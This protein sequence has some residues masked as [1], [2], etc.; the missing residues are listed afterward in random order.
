MAQKSLKI[1]GH[2]NIESFNFF[3]QQEQYNIFRTSEDFRKRYF[4]WHTD[5]QYK[6]GIDSH[7]T[8]AAFFNSLPNRERDDYYQTELDVIDSHY[9]KFADASVLE[10]GCGDGNLTWKLAQRCKQLES[11]D[12]DAG[13][14]ALTQQRV[15]ELLHIDVNARVQDAVEAGLQPT[16]QYDVVFFVQVLEHI[17][18]WDQEKA[19]KSIWNLV[20]PGGVL[21]ISTPNQWRPLDAH[22]TGWYFIHW[23]PRFIKVPLAKAFGIGLKTQDPSWPYPPVLHDYVSFH[24]MCKRVKRWSPG[25]TAS[26]M[27]FYPNVDTWYAYKTQKIKGGAKLWVAKGI[28]VLG[29]FLPLN[30]YFGVKVIFR[31]AD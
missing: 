11:W 13:G 12:L 10:V 22:D 24:W 14:V 27:E 25:S 29:Q 16:K 15:K 5:G 23:P 1:D 8:Q 21:F 20:K 6:D 26:Q 3:M 18:H 31:K 19:F 2:P 9:H 7:K 28:R 17:P 30:Y 4:T